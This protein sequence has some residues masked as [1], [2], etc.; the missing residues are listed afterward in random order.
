MCN[1]PTRILRNSTLEEGKTLR[2][3]DS[4]WRE[5]KINPILTALEGEE[6]AE[7]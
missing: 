3:I 6:S 5:E 2:S 4:Y 1:V 7:D